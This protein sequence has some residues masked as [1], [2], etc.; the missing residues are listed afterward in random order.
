MRLENVFNNI[1]FF[2]RLKSS[3]ESSYI[4]CPNG[5]LT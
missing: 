4:K 1:F 5:I 2:N 3:D